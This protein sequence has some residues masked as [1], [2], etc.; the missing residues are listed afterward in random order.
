MKKG[1]KA[2]VINKPMQKMNPKGLKTEPEFKFEIDED[3]LKLLSQ[4]FIMLG[5]QHKLKPAE[6]V[7]VLGLAQEI[8]AKE[9]GFVA[10]EVRR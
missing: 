1:M 10:R 3:K 9:I 2:V 4:E 5:Q 7:I 6:L 8:I